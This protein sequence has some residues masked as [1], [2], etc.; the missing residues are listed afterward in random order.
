[1]TSMVKGS[2]TGIGSRTFAA[3]ELDGIAEDGNLTSLF[4]GG[5]CQLWSICR[6]LPVLAELMT[7]IASGLGWI[8]PGVSI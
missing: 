6:R 5:F 8:V 2:S 1:M 3:G 4:W 7:M